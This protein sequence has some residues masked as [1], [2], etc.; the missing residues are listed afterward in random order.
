MIFLIINSVLALIGIYISWKIYL[1]KR[2]R[3]EMVCYL[4][5]ECGDILN[6][7][8]SKFF[9]IEI[10]YIG[11]AY[12]AALL[13][14]YLSL[15]FLDLSSIAS[16][17]TSLFVI[18]LVGFVFSL[19][20]IFVQALYIKEWCP[21][22][23]A[24]AMVSVVIFA[25]STFVSTD[26][27]SAIATLLADHINLLMILQ[28]IG[29]AIGVSGATIS[30]ILTVRFLKDFRIDIKEE[31][32]LT[33][34]DQIIWLAI[35]ILLVVNV[36]FYLIDPEVYFGSSRFVAGLIIF[37]ILLINNSLLSL[38]L[39]P[40]LIGIRIDMKSIHVLKTFWLRQLALALGVISII[41][42]YAILFVAFLNKVSVADPVQLVSNYIAATIIAIILSQVLILWVDKIKR[43]SD[44]KYK[45]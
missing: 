10:E 32:K 1:K 40:K 5:S 35:T 41:S 39:G 44:N 22:C 19:Y 15:A 9:G 18:S 28:L 38:Y 13:L 45:F 8:F 31:K 21:L 34:L 7:K 16:L 3:G 23:L 17:V 12:Y 27:S 4:G 30:G 6:S 42:W 14:G 26:Y 24:S 43:T 25:L 11:F 33:F 2:P 20:L 36:C 37:V 29:I